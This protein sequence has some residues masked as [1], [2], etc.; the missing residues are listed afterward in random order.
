M[1]GSAVKLLSHPVCLFHCA[2][3]SLARLRLA[4]LYAHRHLAAGA[5]GGRH[6][7]IVDAATVCQHAAVAAG[8]DSLPA[9]LGESAQDCAAHQSRTATSK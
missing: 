6:D 3:A 1:L 8:D 9:G 4:A 5:V 7:V 2:G